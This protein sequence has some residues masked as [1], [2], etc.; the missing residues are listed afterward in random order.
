[1]AMMGSS[2]DPAMTTQIRSLLEHPD[3]VFLVPEGSELASRFLWTKGQDL[4]LVAI[5]C[6]NNSYSR[7]PVKEAKES[8]FHKLALW[9]DALNGLE[10]LDPVYK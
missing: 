2:A 6:K 1:M 7:S 3:Q 5:R 10:A 8:D 9:L 4:K